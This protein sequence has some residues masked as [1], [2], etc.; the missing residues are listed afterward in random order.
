[1]EY[2]FLF[3]VNFCYIAGRAFQQLNVIHHKKGWLVATSLFL[4]TFEVAL[5]GTITFKAYETLQ[6]SNWL[7]FVLMVIPIWLGGSAG[8]LASMEIHRRLRNAR[9]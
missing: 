9:S 8:S 3:A 5:F 7:P 1:M 6:T 4:A 2:L